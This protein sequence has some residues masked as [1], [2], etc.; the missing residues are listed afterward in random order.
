MKKSENNNDISKAKELIENREK[1]GGKRNL[2]KI[3]HQI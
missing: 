2:K 1:Y 3:D